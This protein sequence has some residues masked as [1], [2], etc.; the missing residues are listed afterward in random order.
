MVFY[1][2]A[3]QFPERNAPFTPHFANELDFGSRSSTLERCFV[4]CYAL[5]RAH[6]R[7]G[8]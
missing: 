8:E 2:G 7:S 4:V 1:E 5:T 3:S 6:P